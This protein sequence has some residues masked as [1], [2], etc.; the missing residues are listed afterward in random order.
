MERSERHSLERL[1]ASVKAKHER[2]RE[3][4]ITFSSKDIFPMI[5]YYIKKKKKEK[6]SD[7]TVR[8]FES[9]T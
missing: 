7:E 1:Y 6:K 5:W 4:R 3:I 2:I 8:F 9:V